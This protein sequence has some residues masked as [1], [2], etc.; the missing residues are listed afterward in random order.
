MDSKLRILIVDDERI[1]RESF[2]HWFANAGHAVGAAAS[3]DEALVRLASEVYDLLFVDIKMPGKSG[4]ELLEQVR[5]EFPEASVVIITAYGSI[6]SAV[7]AMKMGA[8][9]YLLKPFK[10]EQ[11]NLVLEKIIQ[12]RRLSEQ[13]RYLKGTLEQ[14]TRF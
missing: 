9:D 10:P 2:K 13:Y 12:Q 3:A 8:S 14:I 6:E 11:L 7:Q 5:Q 4:L 1:V